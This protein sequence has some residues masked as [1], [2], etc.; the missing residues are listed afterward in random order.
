M[1][2][3]RYFF[4]TRLD[5]NCTIII[6]Y[7]WWLYRDNGPGTHARE[8]FFQSASAV[9]MMVLNADKARA[10]AANSGPEL[11]Q[12]VQRLPCRGCTTAC[13]LYATCNGAPWRM[14]IAVPSA[15]QG[16]A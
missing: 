16:D 2:L 13:G 4:A 15:D 14:S 8:L 10:D 9:N 12:E 11:Q 1:G 3:R 5:K 7:L 6:L